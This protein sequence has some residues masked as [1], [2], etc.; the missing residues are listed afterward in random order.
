MHMQFAG[1]GL[2]FLY[3]YRMFIN[4]KKTVKTTAPISVPSNL[5]SFHG[6]LIN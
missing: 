6:Q 3:V 4:T 1:Y 2:D 5:N